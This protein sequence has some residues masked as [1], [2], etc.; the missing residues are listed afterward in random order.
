MILNFVFVFVNF[1]NRWVVVFGCFIEYVIRV[2]LINVFF[3]YLNGV[4]LIVWCSRVLWI[5]CM[6][7][8]V[9]WFVLCSLVILF[10]V[11]LWEFVIIVDSVFLVISLI[12]V[13]IV[14]L[15][16]RFKVISFV[17]GCLLEKIFG[18]YFIFLNGESVLI[19]VSRNKLEYKR[20]ILV[21]CYCLCRGLSFLWNF[22]GF[23]WRFG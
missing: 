10:I 8:L 9:L 6:Y 2:G 19:T 17:F 5:I 22:C 18:I 14:C 12:S 11:T 7:M 21:F 1:L 20:I 16:W 15:F 13:I 3:R 4:F 23:R